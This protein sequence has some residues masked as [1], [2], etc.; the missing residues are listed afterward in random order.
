MPALLINLV[1]VGNG[2]SWVALIANTNVRWFFQG[3]TLAE[4][5]KKMQQFAECIGQGE[6]GNAC[7]RDVFKGEAVEPEVVFST[8]EIQLGD[9]VVFTL[10]EGTFFEAT[11]GVLT[12]AGDALE[13][14]ILAL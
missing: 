8:N 13:V 11:D 12:M 9:E 3:A 7:G 5:V 14:A 10:D 4:Q 6:L 1:N 2:Q